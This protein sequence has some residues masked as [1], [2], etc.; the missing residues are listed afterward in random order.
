MCHVQLDTMTDV[1]AKD[2]NAN[3]NSC[4]DTA[5]KTR[6]QPDQTY[7]CIWTLDNKFQ[8]ALKGEKCAMMP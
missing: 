6:Y 5:E 2:Q 1:H 8:L 3:V 4:R 7:M